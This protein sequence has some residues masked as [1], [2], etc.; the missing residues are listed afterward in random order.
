MIAAGAWRFGWNRDVRIFIPRAFGGVLL[1]CADVFLLGLLYFN[2]RDAL[3]GPRWAQKSAAKVVGFGV[4]IA[5]VVMASAV[6]LELFNNCDFADIAGSMYLCGPLA[7][8]VSLVSILYAL[9]SGPIEI[10]HTVWSCL[11]I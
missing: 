3:L 4:L 9:K 5:V 8:A 11:E 1:V 7:V 2:L 10:A 6:A